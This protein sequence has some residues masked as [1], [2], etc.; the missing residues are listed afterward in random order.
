MLCQQPVLAAVCPRD[1]HSVHLSRGI[2]LRRYKGYG[3]GPGFSFNNPFART[4][5]AS[6]QLLPD[7][8]FPIL[9]E[10][11]VASTFTT[12]AAA[13]KLISDALNPDFEVARLRFEAFGG[14]L[15][16][17]DVPAVVA[18]YFCCCRFLKL[19]TGKFRELLYEKFNRKPYQ[20]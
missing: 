15:F 4:S 20:Y 7:I 19:A 11:F 17:S 5:E 14:Y 2:D 18:G 16:S 3:P 6:R 8:P 10:S 1:R 12:V 13:H 9:D